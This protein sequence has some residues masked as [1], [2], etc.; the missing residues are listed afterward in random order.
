MHKVW[1]KVMQLQH[2]TGYTVFNPIW[3]NRSYPDL[4]TL[5]YAVGWQ[6]YGITHKCHIFII[7]STSI[8]VWLTNIHLYYLQLEQAI[9][10]QKPFGALHL[11]PTPV[12]NFLQQTSLF[13]RI[14][15][16]MLLVDHLE[17]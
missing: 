1:A 9:L 4:A 8:T 3:R 13:Q 10:A 14:Y 15:F 16:Q 2:V 5:Q 17:N 11:F 6:A 7:C 12:F